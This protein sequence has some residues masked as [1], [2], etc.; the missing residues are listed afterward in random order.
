MAPCS[1]GP[2]PRG[3][4]GRHIRR[5]LPILR[6]FDA[7]AT[8]ARAE[9][10]LVPSRCPPLRRGLGGRT[11]G[12]RIRGQQTGFQK[13][14]QVLADALLRDIAPEGSEDVRK[15]VV[16]SD[17]RQ[18][19]AKLS[20][21]MRQ[22]HHLDTVRQVLV[23]ALRR[24]GQGAAAF[25]KQAQRQVLEPSEQVAA[26]TFLQA[27]P[28]D[29]SIPSMGAGAAAG[30]LCPFTPGQT[31]GQAA[32]AILARAATAPYLLG[33]LFRDAERQLLSAGI[34]P[35]GYSKEALWTDHENRREAGEI[36]TTGPPFRRWSAIATLRRPNKNIYPGSGISRWRP[37]SMWSS[38]R[39]DEA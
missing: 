35:G 37:L 8:P 23:D 30:T 7:S 20:A 24:S 19:A 12:S 10:A 6:A 15:L 32:V 36:C 21:G 18:D 31:Y 28:Q 1:A 22:A 39:D 27:L 34:N 25:F 33:E 14:A 16:F 4:H 5:R 9:A 2:P 11:V 29:A 17:S 13:I 38:P 26:A 3:R